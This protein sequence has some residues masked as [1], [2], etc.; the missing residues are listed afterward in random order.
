ML[1][2]GYGVIWDVF[3]IHKQWF[4]VEKKYTVSGGDQFSPTAAVTPI[5]NAEDMF[6]VMYQMVEITTCKFLYDHILSCRRW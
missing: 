3:V 4:L 5:Y 6:I 2:A 1:D